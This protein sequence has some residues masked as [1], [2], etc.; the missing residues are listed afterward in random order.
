MRLPAI[1]IVGV[2][3]A[4]G[5]ILLALGP[6]AYE[7]V[8]GMSSP[9]ARIAAVRE[10]YPEVCHVPPEVLRSLLESKAE[11]LVIDLRSGD[12]FAT[13]HV[14]GAV[15]LPGADANPIHERIERQAPSPTMVVCYDKTGRGSAEV[16]SKLSGVVSV[17][18]MNLAGGYDVWSRLAVR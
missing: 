10:D 12:E 17:P 1:I 16:A 11:L 8:G 4:F 14:P 5:L 13:S 6:L 15:S 3:F 2:A 9:D 18:V 7:K